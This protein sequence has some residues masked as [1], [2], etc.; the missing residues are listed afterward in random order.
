MARRSNARG[1]ALAV[2]AVASL[3][4]L[5]ACPND[6]IRGDDGL[7]IGGP[8]GGGPLPGEPDATPTI[9]GTA[10]ATPCDMTGAWIGELHTTSTALGADQRATNWYYFEITQ[11]GERF[12]IGKALH[13]GF[14]VEGTTSVTLADATLASLA[15]TE[16]AGPGRQ[17]TFK[18]TADNQSCTFS[19]DRTYNIR[20]ANKAMYLTAVWNVGDPPKA[21]NTFP[22]LPK[23]PPGMED[24]EMDVQ[25][26][27]TLVT[28]LG[29]RYVAQRDWTEHLGTVPQFAT[30]FGVETGPGKITV[31]WDSQE[32]VSDQTSPILRTTATPKG[33]GW[34]RFARAEGRLTP[35]ATDLQTCKSVQQLA[36]DI[37]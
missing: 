5:A 19:L 11:S 8:D 31:T 17:G 4:C 28:G 20:G 25:H 34:S 15:S 13:C 37:W 27:I 7:P 21:L 36:R 10:P 3:A 33:P 14:I 18:P 35:G 26:G 12:T 16:Y 24:W 2:T 32:A 23:V 29:K 30:E 1:W 22:Q 9:D 6:G